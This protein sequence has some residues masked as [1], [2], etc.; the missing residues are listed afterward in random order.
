MTNLSRHDF[1]V[2]ATS[3][4]ERPEEINAIVPKFLKDIGY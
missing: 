3:P 4:E 1:A 2:R